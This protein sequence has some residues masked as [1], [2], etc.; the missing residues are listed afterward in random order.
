VK[1]FPIVASVALC[2]AFLPGIALAEGGAPTG[3]TSA[4][5]SPYV[6]AIAPGH[7]GD[8]PGAIYPPD[9]DHPSIEEKTLTLPIALK[10]RD[11][12]AHEDVTVVMTRT[13]DVTTTAE[14]RAAVAEQAQAKIFVAVHVNSYLPDGT[15]R[16]AEAQYFSDPAFA[17][18]VADGLVSSLRE[19]QETVRTTKD[20][21]QDNILSMPGVIVEAGYLSNSADRKLLQ[22]DAYQSAIAE[23]IY[24][25]ILTYAPQIPALKQQIEAYKAVR[26]PASKAQQPALVVPNLRRGLPGW[27][28]AAGIF[29]GLGLALI[30]GRGRSRRR[31]PRRRGYATV[32][33]H[34]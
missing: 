1:F 22:T 21:E 6:V 20:R 5:P 33:R 23:G 16:G 32:V 10:L 24:Q 13:P 34:R 4:P 29:G 28:P 12:L 31:A 27:L 19:F 2:S 8:D 30:A 26:A 11:K 14:Q 25:G 7:G 15:I 18:D 3:P 9:S 17:D